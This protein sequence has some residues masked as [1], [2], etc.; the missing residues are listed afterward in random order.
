MTLAHYIVNRKR[1][2]GEALDVMVAKR[3]VVMRKVGSYPV[4]LRIVE[5]QG[6]K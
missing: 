3:P 2:A 4:I 6:V 5:E 1:D